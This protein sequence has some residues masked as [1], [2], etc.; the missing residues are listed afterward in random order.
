MTI[1]TRLH[2]SGWERVA[3]TPDQARIY[4]ATYPDARIEA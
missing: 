1:I 3:M 2:R 4:L